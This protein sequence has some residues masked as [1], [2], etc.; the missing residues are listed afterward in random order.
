VVCIA[1]TRKI[2]KSLVFM[3]VTCGFGCWWQLRYT[4]RVTVE[5]KGLE[6]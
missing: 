6:P 4:E 5:T 2:T 3:D 1:D